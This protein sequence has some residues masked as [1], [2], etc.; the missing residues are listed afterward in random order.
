MV[1]SNLQ[2]L[3]STM[4]LDKFLITLKW[5]KGLAFLQDFKVKPLWSRVSEMWDSGLQDFSLIRELN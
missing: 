1:E 2:V 5:Q 3:E 4:L